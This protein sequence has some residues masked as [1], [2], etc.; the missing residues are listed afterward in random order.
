M[1]IDYNLEVLSVKH[2][3]MAILVARD[4]CGPLPVADESEFTKYVTLLKLEN[5]L[6]SLLFILKIFV[7]YFDLFLLSVKRICWLLTQ[8][9]NLIDIQFDWF[10]SFGQLDLFF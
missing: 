7:R 2:S 8:F 6:E 3:K 10:I 9:L 4:S 1:L 5:V